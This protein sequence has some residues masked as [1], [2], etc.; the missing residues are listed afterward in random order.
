MYY[1][2]IYINVYIQLPQERHVVK[3][4]SAYNVFIFETLIPKMPS[5]PRSVYI[6]N[7]KYNRYENVIYK[8]NHSIKYM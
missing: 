8:I 6:V 1:I 7:N 3:R 2:Y 5:S 4:T